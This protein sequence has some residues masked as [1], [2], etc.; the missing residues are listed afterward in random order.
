M[1]KIKSSSPNIHSAS[2]LNTKFSLLYTNIYQ[3]PQYI[4]RLNQIR[5]V[6]LDIKEYRKLIDLLEKHDIPLPS[7][8]NDA[9]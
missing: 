5:Y 1:I 6:A 4:T 9:S 3:T 7:Y 2:D 8:F